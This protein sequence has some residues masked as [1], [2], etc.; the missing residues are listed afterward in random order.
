MR[1]FVAQ[2][3]PKLQESDVMVELNCKHGAKPLIEVDGKAL[4]TKYDKLDNIL[5]DLGKRLG[6]K[7]D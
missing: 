1:Q 3:V 7:W 5:K 6:M 4:K 2:H